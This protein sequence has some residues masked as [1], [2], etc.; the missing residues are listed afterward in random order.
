MGNKTVIITGASRG[1]GKSAA[2]LF[3]RRGFN[4]LVNY[5]HSEEEAI[6]LVND[7][8]NQGSGLATAY[9]ADVADRIQ[10]DRMVQFCLQKFGG[11]D[12]IVNNAGITR[13]NLFT[14]ILPSE[15]DEVMDVNLKGVF[16]CCQSVLPCMMEKKSGSIVN[17]SSIWGLTGASCEVHYSA[18]KAAVIGLTKALAKELG[19]YNIKVN[20]VCPGVINTDMLNE[21]NRQD[22]EELEKATP[23]MRLGTPQDV[24]HCIYFLASP[25]ASFITGQV[26]SPNG[27]FV[28]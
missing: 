21:L 27:G 10:V 7:L 6:K 11:I 24:A 3:G 17:V 16:N 2:E 15:W 5:R 8:N 1:I 9:Q 12:V 23:L 4:V 19:S 22:I 28:I 20:C 26:L 13:Q 25:E 14:D 18:A